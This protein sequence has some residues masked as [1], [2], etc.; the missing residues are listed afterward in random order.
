MT[1]ASIRKEYDETLER[2][3]SD[4]IVINSHKAEIAK[5]QSRTSI[6]QKRLL[7]IEL[8]WLK[9]DNCLCALDGIF[10]DCEVSLWNTENG[11]AA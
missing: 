1:R 4:E 7:L 5:L 8:E 9:L 6:D 10:C 11:G 2:I 3:E